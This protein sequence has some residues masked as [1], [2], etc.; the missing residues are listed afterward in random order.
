MSTHETVA[1]E[2]RAYRHGL[3][4]GLTLAEVMLLLVFVLLI[5]MAAIWKFERKERLKLQAPSAAESC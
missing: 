1:R 5:T 2:S 4:L 3:V